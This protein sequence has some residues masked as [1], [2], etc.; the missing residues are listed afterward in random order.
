M[1][2][3]AEACGVSKAAL[4]HYVADKYQ[5]LVEIAEGHIDRLRALLDDETEAAKREKSLWNCSWK[6]FTT[7]DGV[8]FVM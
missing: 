7:N 4:Y 5:L 2:R 3:V 6:H 8:V 1:N